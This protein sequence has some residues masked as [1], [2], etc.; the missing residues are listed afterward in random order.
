MANM[1]NIDWRLKGAFASP[2]FAARIAEPFIA[3]ILR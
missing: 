2:P 1:A 3:A